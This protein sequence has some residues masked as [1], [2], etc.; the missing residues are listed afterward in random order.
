MER[1]IRCFKCRHTLLKEADNHHF[2]SPITCDLSE[3]TTKSNS[4]HLTEDKLPE[5]IR[6]KVEAENWTKGKLHCANCGF[7]VGSFDFISGRK[8]EC[9]SSVMPSVHFISSQVDILSDNK[10]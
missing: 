3:C 10:Y 4:I 8:C 6:Q 2:I 1:I 7:K 9:G 5:W